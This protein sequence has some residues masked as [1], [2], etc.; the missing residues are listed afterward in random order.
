[1]KAAD[2]LGLMVPLSLQAQA[3]EVIE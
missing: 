2:A 3:H 1:M